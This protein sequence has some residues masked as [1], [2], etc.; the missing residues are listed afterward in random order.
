MTKRFR[1]KLSG[2]LDPQELAKV[3]TSFDIVGDI[4]IIKTPN[5]DN[6]NAQTV[7]T[8]IMATHKGVK[9]VLIQTSPILGQF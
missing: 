3:Y 6:V 2:A 1:E 9:T 7:A 5:N 8:Q 4:A